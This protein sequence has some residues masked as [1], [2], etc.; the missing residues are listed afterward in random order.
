MKILRLKI[1]DKL[2][3]IIRDIEFAGVGISFIYGD[4]QDPKNLG[5]TINSLGKTLLIKCIDYI[6]GA[7]EDSKIIKDDIHGYILEAVIK[8]D[9]D[10]YLISR[11]L[12]SSEEILINNKPYSLAE[13][14]DFFNIKRS[15]YGKQII[16]NKKVSE[17]SYRAKPNKDD[18][19]N[20]L[21]LLGLNDI[22]KSIEEIYK[23]QDTI[24]SYKKN[25][26]ELISFYGD[27]DL[28][29]I[30]EEIY[31]V[32]KEVKRLTDELDIISKKIK[33]IEVSEMQINIVEEYAN[34]SAKLKRTKSEYEKAKLECSRLIEFIE[35]SNKVDISSEHILAIYEKTKQ[36][37]PDLVK[38]KIQEV[39]AFHKKVFDERKEFLNS[40]KVTIE[41]NIGKLEVEI[42]N[43]STEIDKL[44]K[45]I[46]LNQ[47]YQ[48]SIELY[49]KYNSD[50]QELKY[51]EGKLS[52]VKNID[53]NINTEDSNLTINF[54]DASKGV[55]KYKELIDEYRDFIYSITK[56][57]YDEDVN[58]YF[59]IKIKKK[60]QTTRPV[61]L[62]INLKGDTGEGVN[63]VK[64]NL[65][66][67]LLFRY[68]TYMELLIQD[69][70]CYNGIDPRQVSSML[71]EVSN[72]AKTTNKQ[73]IIAINKYQ[74][75]EYEDV[76][77]LVK[78]NSSIILSEKDKLF[79]FDF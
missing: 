40:K 52:Q 5:A 23:S 24:K 53:D 25:K 54:D 12:G 76:I 69:S 3:E 59:D 78:S 43:L 55:T 29:Q 57:I 13:Y 63:E 42:E 48:E 17:I 11:T 41:K 21:N 72:I 70:S 27:F 64:K 19:V 9:N 77:K 56:S 45:I 20:F 68:N 38:R 79:G 2:G 39:E 26:L 60:H 28:K 67:Y 31:F 14:K 51:K 18:Y 74:L 15:V 22:I 7:N 36:E 62:E 35:N 46:S 47:V 71:T 30:D 66:D 44:G 61:L 1:K 73:A 49:E 16:V 33:T 34:K 8:Y 65:M 58:S 6:Y 50:L 4:I 37:I 10:E 75:G 32:D